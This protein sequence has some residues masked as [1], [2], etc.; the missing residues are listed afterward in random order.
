[1][2]LDYYREKWTIPPYMSPN[3]IYGP[4]LI[5]INEIK[6]FKELLQR[7]EKYDR[8]HNQAN[9]GIEEKKRQFLNFA[10]EL[11]IDIDL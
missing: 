8:E 2:I 1:M 7:A 9:C 10:K 3:H 6:E 11:S 4:P 5:S